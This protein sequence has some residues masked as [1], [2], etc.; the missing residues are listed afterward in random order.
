VEL[1][2]GRIRGI[3]VPLA[4][5]VAAAAQPGEVLVSS[6]VKDLIAGSDIRFAERGFHVLKG[7]AGEWS[8]FA[9]A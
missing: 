5:R 6:T 2:G 8:L 7:I 4:A 3:A 9:V 1:T